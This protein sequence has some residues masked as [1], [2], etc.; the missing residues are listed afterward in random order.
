MIEWK[1]RIVLLNQLIYFMYVWSGPSHIYMPLS[2][3]AKLNPRVAGPT[4]AGVSFEVCLRA[5][6][7]LLYADLYGA[8]Q[9]GTV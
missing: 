3:I 6:N 7:T 1:I 2:E 5:K 4:E 9:Q 8:D